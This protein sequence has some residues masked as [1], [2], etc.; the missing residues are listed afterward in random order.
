[1]IDKRE[2]GQFVGRW[3][4]AVL[5]CLSVQCRV[6]SRSAPAGH[7]LA[8]RGELLFRGMCDASGA[9]ALG[10]RHFAVADDEDNVLR[11]YDAERPGAPLSAV[12][13]S[14][15]LGLAD[16]VHPRE[17]D[18]EAATRLG[19]YALWMTS[20]GLTRRGKREPARFRFFATTAPKQ[21]LNLTPVGQP[22]EGLLDDMLQTPALAV[23][24]LD[25]AARQS[26]KR[27]GG[28]NIE[29]LTVRTDGRS[30]LIG[31]RNPRPQ[32]KALLIPLL[33][34][35]EVVEG[36]HAA[37]GP[38]Q[39]LDLGGLGIR[40]LG[41]WQSGYVISAGAA[42]GG[43]AARMYLWSGQSDTVQA[44]AL[45]LHDFNP[46]ALVAFDGEPRVL[47]LSDD[48]TRRIGRERCKDLREPND[49]QFRGRWASLPNL[50]GAP[51][52]PYGPSKTSSAAP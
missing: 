3:L 32:G 51:R 40:S 49:K 28:L 46:E 23:F 31:F 48:G 20:H 15:A 34:P 22:Y 38:A 16:R 29:G 37:F 24:D 1:M 36:K 12:D 9:V 43:D 10:M 14:A 19:P 33:N 26:P 27:P 6:A 5:A 47:L 52:S 25:V 4:L 8:D 18:I 41:R 11:I 50:A 2:P 17:A 21:G 42:D 44:V 39:L 45:D 7:A 30:V 35:L 13:V